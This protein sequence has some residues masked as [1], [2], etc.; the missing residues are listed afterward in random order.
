MSSPDI[1]AKH[2]YMF[3]YIIVGDSNVGKSCLLLQFTDNKFRQNHE[4]TIGVEFGGKTIKLQEK[5]IK[6]QIWDT[7]GQEVYQAITRGYYKGAT[8]AFVVYD[9]TKKE[10]FEH[11]ERW[12]ED[13]KTNASKDIQ[14]ILI[15]NKKDLEN[16]RVVSFD[17]GASLA[18]KYGILFLE[19]SAKTAYNVNEAFIKSAQK[20]LDF[21]LKNGVDLNQNQNVK[22]STKDD[23]EE[24]I[25]KKKKCFCN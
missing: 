10:T 3:R 14:I 12:L 1:E 6:I 8:G 2:D 9:I 13:V 18:E 15:G 11:V 24:V 16:E 19:T 20:I 23:D 25:V 22:I 4:A 7:A 21:I 5:I 17:E